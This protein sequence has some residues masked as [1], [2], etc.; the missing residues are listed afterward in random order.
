MKIRSIV[1]G[2]FAAG[3]FSFCMAQMSFPFMDI[4]KDGI[5][6]EE[7][8]YQAQAKNM[9]QRASENRMMKNA[10]KAP[11]FSD[12]DLNHDGKVTQEEYN[13]FR[14]QRMIENRSK[15]N[16]RGSGYGNGRGK[17]NGNN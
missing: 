9:E 4:N 12:F 16:F 6:S 5:V 17:G 14:S 13:K 7:E 1:I 15:N 8:F 2:L 10:G 3:S 11:Q